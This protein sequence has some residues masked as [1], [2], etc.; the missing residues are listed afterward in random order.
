M[1]CKKL[2][3]NL[4]F[5]DKLHLSKG[6]DLRKHVF[7]LCCLKSV[8]DFSREGCQNVQ[9]NQNGVGFKALNSNLFNRGVKHLFFL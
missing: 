6:I 2:G 3:A 1:Q 7:V 4:I 8:L 9:R 5:E